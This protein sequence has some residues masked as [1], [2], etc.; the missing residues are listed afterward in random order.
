MHH[1]SANAQTGCIALFHKFG[2]GLIV[3]QAGLT[4]WL[5]ACLAVFMAQAGFRCIIFTDNCNLAESPHFLEPEWM[6]VLWEHAAIIMCLYKSF[7]SGGKLIAATIDCNV[8]LQA[9]ARLPRI[10]VFD[11]LADTSAIGIGPFGPQTS[12]PV[13]WTFPGF[14]QEH[15]FVYLPGGLDPQSEPPV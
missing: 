12:L 11:A 15:E 1:L 14:P 13:R 9:A 4:A 8:H 10:S 3:P 6:H 5:T 2:M 7:D